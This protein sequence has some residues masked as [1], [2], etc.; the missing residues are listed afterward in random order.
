MKKLFSAINAPGIFLAPWMV[1]GAMTTGLVLSMPV[2]GIAQQQSPTYSAEEQAALKEADELNEQATK[3][4][5]EGKYSAAIPLAE[6]TLAITE[7]VLGQEHPDVALS[8]NN[9][10]ALY[11]AQGNYRQAEP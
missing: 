11:E 3:L 7:K 9:L 5:Q 8:L 4:Y 10:A 1:A 2:E 6:R